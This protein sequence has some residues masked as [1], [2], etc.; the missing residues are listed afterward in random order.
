MN[1]IIEEAINKPVPALRV[2]ESVNVGCS[3]LPED[4]SH[5]LKFETTL[6]PS[7]IEEVEKILTSMLYI[8]KLDEEGLGL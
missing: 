4:L 3:S 8:A 1:L 2:E 6:R 5:R 7:Q